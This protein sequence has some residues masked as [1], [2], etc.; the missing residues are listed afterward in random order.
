MPHDAAGQRIGGFEHRCRWRRIDLEVVGAIT[1]AHFIGGANG[2][3]G[4]VERVAACLEARHIERALRRATIEG[5]L[6]PVLCGSALKNRGIQM[7]LDAIVLYLPSPQDLPA[8]EGTH[9]DTGAALVRPPLDD[10]PVCA[11]AFKVV[12]DRAQGTLTFVRVEARTTRG[13][14]GTSHHS[15]STVSTR[16][17]Q[18]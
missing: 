18:R 6:V 3:E 10:A 7:L 14:A 5:R 2:E 11:L 9:P 17:S 12:S 4:V 13:T 1:R 15:V 16:C 8:V